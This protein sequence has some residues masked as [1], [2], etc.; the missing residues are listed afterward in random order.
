MTQFGAPAVAELDVA[1]LR[2]LAGQFQSNCVAELSRPF[3][4]DPIRQLLGAVEAVLRSWNAQRAIEYLRLQGVSDEGG[5][6]VTVQAM[7]F[8]NKGVMS[9]SG[10]GFI[11]DPATGEKH[12]YADF[13]LDAQGQDLVAGTHAT[14]QPE[15]AIASIPGLDHQLRSIC[16]TLEAIFTDPQ[17][18]EFTVEDGTLWL[19]QTRAAKR[20]PW[21]ALQI[22][23]DL[24]D[25]GLIDPDTALERL[26][27]YDLHRISRVLA[28]FTASVGSG[29]PTPT[30]TRSVR[31][32]QPESASPP[33]GSPCDRT[34]RSRR[35]DTANP[36]SWSANKRP[37]NTSPP[38]PHVA[39]LTATGART[40]HAAVVARQLGVVCFVNGQ[41]MT[42]DL[43]AGRLSISGHH[44]DENDPTAMTKPGPVS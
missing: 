6:A 40:S 38:W 16:A 33:A 36:S 7:V 30:G 13:L 42:I 1:A 11:R 21:A 28:T 41:H 43:E 3:P 10:V 34:P 17:D 9:G 8:A 4:Q 31:Q 19:L 22:A 37:P 2:D 24:V 44:L 23:C 25:E 14:G 35:L 12:L 29:S 32:H 39:K 26:R 5:T 15:S 18:F 27:P 20:T